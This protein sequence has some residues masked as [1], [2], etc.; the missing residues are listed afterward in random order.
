MNNTLGPTTHAELNLT[1]QPE[2]VRCKGEPEL[3]TSPEPADQFILGDTDEA[4]DLVRKLAEI[5]REL[6]RNEDLAVEMRKAAVA[7]GVQLPRIPLQRID[8]PSI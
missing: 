5:T 4:T 2:F 8:R 7:K 1:L 6:E 3:V